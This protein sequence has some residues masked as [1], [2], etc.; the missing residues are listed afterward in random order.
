MWRPV[1][2]ARWSPMSTAAN[3]IRVAPI[4]RIAA[5]A[6][7]CWA[8][9]PTEAC[10][11][12]SIPVRLL[13]K[14]SKLTLDQLALV[15]TLGIGAHA[16]TRSGIQR[17]QRALIVGAGPIGL[18]VFQ[19]LQAIGATGVIR[20]LSELRRQFA[21]K[22][23]A[24]TQAQADGELFEYV[25]DA[26]GNAASMEASFE[27]VNFAGKLVF[28]GLVTGRISFDD[29]FFHRREM[30]LIASRNSC[31]EF[32]RLIRLIEEGVIDTTPW[33]TDRLQLSAVPDQFESLYGRPQL[34]KCMIEVE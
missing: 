25:F 5:N 32:P 12:S 18:A 31:H 11:G 1:I 29:P 33:I 9:T 3:A 15:E 22:L 24:E 10:A 26:T 28:V 20:E 8:F 4:A 21:E 27:S 17:G 23:G 30:T 34:L 2:S 6:C 7:K 14:S 19:S 16:V 13:H